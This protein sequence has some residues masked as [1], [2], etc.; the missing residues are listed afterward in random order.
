VIFFQE[1]VKPVAV[2]WGLLLKVPIMQI[3]YDLEFVNTRPTTAVRAVVL[4]ESFPL[5]RSGR[6]HEPD[7][8]DALLAWLHR[9]LTRLENR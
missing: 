1:V 6:R 9:L 3:P 7:A 2:A 5:A 8:F 4:D